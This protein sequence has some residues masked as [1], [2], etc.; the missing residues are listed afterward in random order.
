MNIAVFVSGNGTNLQAIIDA[1]KRRYL[2]CTIALVVS[3]NKNAYALTR[4]RKA[5]IEA[6][7]LSPD[8]FKTREAYDKRVM[9][10]L[11]R[12]NIK[13]VVLAGFMRLLSPYFVR[14]Y[15]NRIVNIHPALLPSFKGTHGI[16]DAF[17][18]GVK[19]TGVT[20]HFV[21][22]ELDHGPIIAQEAVRIRGDDTFKTVEARIHKVEHKLYPRVIRSLIEKK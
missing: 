17:R 13:L 9:R 21:D 11:A 8:G 1:V 12:C 16:L 18:Y 4:A 20:V 5:G 15:K 22:D 3:S 19:I 6:L 14:R 7:V 2:K 10:E